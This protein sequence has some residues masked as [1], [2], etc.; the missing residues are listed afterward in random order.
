MIAPKWFI[1]DLEVVDKS[2]FPAWN[3]K[4]GYWEIKK[5]MHEYHL[6]HRFFVEIKDPTIGVFKELN[7]NAL[8]NIRMRRRL[9]LK[10]PGKSYYK[11]ILDQAKESR[12][13]KSQLAVEMATEGMMKIL[14]LGKSKQ[15]DMAVP[16]KN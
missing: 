14:N 7:N 9:S 1:K 13:K 2:Y 12:E 5:K 4:M 10:Y 16:D 11:W 15:F 6:F 8:D 3:E